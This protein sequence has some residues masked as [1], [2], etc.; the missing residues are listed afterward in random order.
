MRTRIPDVA[1][2]LRDVPEDAPVLLL[3]H[4]PDLFPS[5]PPRVSLTLA[6]HTHGGQVDVPVL[7]LLVV[8]SGTATALPRRPWSRRRAASIYIST[9]VGTRGTAAAL[10]AAARG[11]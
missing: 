6:G 5:V 1:R 2:T 9:G 3:A 7:R 8:P 10:P 11:R 4:D